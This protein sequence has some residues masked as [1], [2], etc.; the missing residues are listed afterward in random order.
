MSF[1]GVM[2]DISQCSSCSKKWTETDI[3]TIDQGGHLWCENCLCEPTKHAQIQ[4]RIVKLVNYI[5]RNN[6]QTIEKIALTTT[7]ETALK[8]LTNLFLR[9]YINGEIVSERILAQ[10]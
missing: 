4:F 9:N 8:T 7:E 10:F 2:P 1:L 6:L 3:I 5:G